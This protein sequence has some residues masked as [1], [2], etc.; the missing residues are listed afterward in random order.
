MCS[1]GRKTGQGQ[2]DMEE[3]R[4]VRSDQPLFYQPFLQN[5]G[6]FGCSVTTLTLFSLLFP[7]F[8]FLV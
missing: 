3:G 1:K 7:F 2:V 6:L 8:F 5:A 4:A